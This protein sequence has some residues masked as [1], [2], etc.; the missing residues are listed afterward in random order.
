M[1]KYVQLALKAL[2]IMITADDDEILQDSCWAFS[3]L[4]DIDSNS[5]EMQ[6][7]GAIINSGSLNRLIKLL[8]HPSPHVRH[9]A[10]RT[11]G[12]IVTGPDQ[13]TQYVLNLGVLKK[14]QSLISHDRAPIKRE[15]CW[16]IS[17]ITAGSKD[18]IEAVIAANLF[19]A[20]IQVLRTEKYEIS[21]EALWGIS[22]A[23]SGGTDIQIKFLVNQGVIPP[24]CKFLNHQMGHKKI[25]LVALE[26]IENILAVGARSAMNNGRNQFATY[27][28]ECGGVDYLEQLQS[29]QSIPDEI[30]DKAASIIKE[31]FGGEEA[32][33]LDQP[34]IFVNSNNNNN[35]NN[36]Q[37]NMGNN[38][39]QN[40]GNMFSFGTGGNNGFN[41]NNNGNG[42]AFNF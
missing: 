22:N 38:Q 21:K 24:L 8:D 33:A 1:G 13:Q 41:N 15:A 36:M 42:G 11:I 6:Q 27:V 5:N 32:D 18:Q 26:G 31:Y 20:L 39:N 14:L 4:S 9:P 37:N 30:Y 2:A 16:T 17:N 29:N 19:P 40:N 12:N 25:L 35:Q 28:E 23:T 34:N 7:I 3:Y 10:L